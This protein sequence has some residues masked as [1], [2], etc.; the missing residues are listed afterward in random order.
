VSRAPTHLVR[1]TGRL[2]PLLESIG[3]AR[4]RP[5]NVMCA[6]GPSFD[7]AL[8]LPRRTLSLTREGFYQ[9]VSSGHRGKARHR[10]AIEV[11]L[12]WPDCFSDT[13]CRNLGLVGRWDAC[14]QK[15]YRCPGC[16][17][18]LTTIW[19]ALRQA[20]V[21]VRTVWKADRNRLQHA[22]GLRLSHLADIEDR[23]SRKTSLIFDFRL[24]PRRG[25]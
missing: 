22:S 3:S 19:V 8:L 10:V 17:H 23:F 13:L 21:P 18:Q 4:S 25:S 5:A 15:R 11:E 16:S 6:S 9:D 1:I 20:S 24:R 14:S 12:V 2:A 7:L